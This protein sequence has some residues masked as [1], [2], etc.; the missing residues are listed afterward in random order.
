MAGKICFQCFKSKGGREVCPHCGYAFFRETEQAYQLAPGT[1]LHKRYVIGVNI[2]I[3][4]F[5]ITYKA[6]DAMLRMIVAVKE[7]YPAG[8]VNRAGGE[9]KV[10]IF[11]GEKKAEFQRQL[12]RFL[13]EARNMALFSKEQD[14]VNV[15]DFFEENQTAYIIMEYVDAPLLKDELKKRRFSPEEAGAYMLALLQALEKVHGHGIIHKDISPDNIFLTG[16]DQIKLFDFGAARLQ[17]A[18]RTEAVVVKAGYTPPEQ[19]TSQDTQSFC[20][21]IYAAGAVFYEMLAG[22]KPV[23]SRDRVIQD[24]LKSFKECGVR[25]DE[26]LQRIV[27]KALALEPRLRFQTAEAFKNALLHRKKVLLPQEELRKNRRIRRTLAAV[28]AVVILLATGALALGMTVFSGRGKIDVAKLKKEELSIW[29]RAED[30]KTGEL[31]TQ[32]LLESAARVCP[33][34]TIH[35]RVIASEDYAGMVQSAAEQDSLP[36]VFCTDGLDAS[37]LEADRCEELSRLLN[38]MDLSEYLYLEQLKQQGEAYAL[39]TAMQ[40]A[41]VYISKAKAGDGAQ[42]VPEAV[43]VDMLAQQSGY[44]GYADTKEQEVFARFQDLSDPLFWIA[45]DLSDMDAVEAVTVEAVPSTDFTAVPVV[46]E[47]KLFACMEHKYAVKKGGD[48]NRQD[49]AMTLLSLLLGEGMQSASFMDNRDGLPLN[50]TV[51]D[52]Y[53]ENKLTTYLHFIKDYS[54]DET[55]VCKEEN[56]CAALRQLQDSD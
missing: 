30:D 37:F 41:V 15:Y 7:F 43:T 18:E 19:Y 48:K 52:S 24:E 53:Q 27:F 44:V 45:G 34:L 14:I 51:L 36:D 47:G 31:L 54:L 16:E 28:L 10:G 25:A 40:T 32:M 17:G 3:G 13:E 21:D 20:M 1:V 49:A 55:E 35:T 9:K 4:G 5:G 29:L 38:T 11:S 39:P 42:A 33:Q 12:A 50:R 46:K 23:D 26:Y 6:F 8:L 56:V 22:E 2:G